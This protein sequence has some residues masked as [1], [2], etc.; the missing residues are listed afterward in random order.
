M[1]VTEAI[2]WLVAIRTER[3]QQKKRT[4]VKSRIMNYNK[5]NSDSIKGKNKNDGESNFDL[6]FKIEIA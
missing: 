2:M 4:G 5:W 3:Y 6:E 1:D